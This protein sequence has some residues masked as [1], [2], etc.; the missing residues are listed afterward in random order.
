MSNF[1][2][3]IV[4]LVNVSVSDGRFTSYAPVTVTVTL[5]TREMRDNAVVIQFQNVLPDEFVIFHYQN[6]LRALR[7]E[8]QVRMFSCDENVCVRIKAAV[9]PCKLTIGMVF[10]LLLLIFLFNPISGPAAGRDDSLNST[11]I[12]LA[13]EAGDEEKASQHKKQ[14]QQQQQ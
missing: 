13:S 10:L 7:T 14:L 4:L 11:V 6:F 5:V 1:T 2:F 3:V 8:M 9:Q 12:S